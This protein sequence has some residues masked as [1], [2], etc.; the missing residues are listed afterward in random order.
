MLKRLYPDMSV[1]TDVIVGFPGEEECDFE[2]TMGVLSEVEFDSIFSFKY[3][4]RPGTRAAG[5]AGRVPE[6]VK[7]ARLVKLQAEQR[8]I[9]TRK[10]KALEGKT[11]DVLVEGPSKA[12]ASE[13]TG[14]APC[15]RVVNFPGDPQLVGSIIDVVIT[16]AYSNSLRAVPMERGLQC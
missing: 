12:S 3:S 6:E 2:A 8:K 4:A 11:I 7:G 9:S 16:E 10:N 14:R 1:T 15:N 5:F 13:L